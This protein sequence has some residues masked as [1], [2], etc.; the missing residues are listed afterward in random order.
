VPCPK[1]L[2][3]LSLSLSLAFA[4]YG[5]T[6][7]WPGT[8]GTRPSAHASESQVTRRPKANAEEAHRTQSAPDASGQVEVCCYVLGH[9]EGKAPPGDVPRRTKAPWGHRAK[10]RGSAPGPGPRDAN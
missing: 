3:A 5:F 7:V 6:V 8:Q 9:Q 2:P 4:C 10:W 1:A